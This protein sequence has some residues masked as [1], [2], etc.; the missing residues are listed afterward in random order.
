MFKARFC[1]HFWIFTQTVKGFKNRIQKI[2]SGLFVIG[3]NKV[4]GCY[5]VIVRFRRSLKFH[6][7]K[8]PKMR[9]LRSAVIG[10]AG[11]A[12]KSRASSSLALLK[13][14]PMGP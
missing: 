10:D 13:L 2:E 6:R 11:P 12:S 7:F 5:Q 3:C 14:A 1:T 4:T 9:A 8:C